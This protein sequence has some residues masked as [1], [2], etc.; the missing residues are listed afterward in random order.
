[1]GA[2]VC[3]IIGASEGI[4]VGTNVAVMKGMAVEVAI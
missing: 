1:V 2:L 4:N 3:V